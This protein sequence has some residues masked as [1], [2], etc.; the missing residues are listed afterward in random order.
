[1]KKR[2]AVIVAAVL[3]AAVAV[4][5]TLAFL[6]DKTPSVENNFQPVSVSCRVLETFDAQ[7]NVKRD[8]SVQNTGD[9]SAYVRVAIVV[10]WVSQENG[11]TYG[12][13]PVAGTDYTVTMGQNGWA[14]GSDGFYYCQ[15]ATAA[16][17]TTPILVSAIAP[18]E[19]RAPEGYVLSVQIVASAIQA[20]PA[21]A[22]SAAWSGV[23]VHDDGTISPK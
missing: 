23:T 20:E 13:A 15:S 14:Q 16:G 17:D 2:I 12:G 9:I 8:V 10:T 4:G 21:E 3:L 1:M 6:V 22:V 11:N 19:G 7:A 5:T 18:V